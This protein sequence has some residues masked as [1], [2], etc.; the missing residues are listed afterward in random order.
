M[1]KFCRTI[2]TLKNHS[3]LILLKYFQLPQQHTADDSVKEE[4]EISIQ[5]FEKRKANLFLKKTIIIFELINCI[6]LTKIKKKKIINKLCFEPDSYV[7]HHFYNP[8]HKHYNRILAERTDGQ[9]LEMYCHDRN[10]YPRSTMI[11]SEMQVNPPQESE[12]TLDFIP[13]QRGKSLLYFNGFTFAKNNESG[14][15]VYWCCRSRKVG[16]PACRARITTS[17]QENGSYRV[18]VTT[19]YHNHSPSVRM[20]KKIEKCIKTEKV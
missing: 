3:K 20:L 14:G 13:G 15:T 11:D 9:P 4:K 1:G 5:E 2:R 8:A 17:K 7:L 10:S 6:K 12:M 18:V 19:P 16:K